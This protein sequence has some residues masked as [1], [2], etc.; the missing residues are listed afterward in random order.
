MD[1]QLALVELLNA[2][3]RHYDD[4][5]L[6]EYFDQVTGKAKEG[7]G[8]GLAEFV[9]RELRETFDEGSACKD[10]IGRALAAMQHA[11][12]DIQSAI[13]GLRELEIECYNS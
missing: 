4:A 1:R 11:A 9:V 8:D 13:S 6:S 10:Q 7:S 5:Y 2:A 12:S 3:N